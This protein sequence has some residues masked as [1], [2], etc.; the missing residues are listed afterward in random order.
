MHIYYA[1]LASEPPLLALAMSHW[2]EG[3]VCTLHQKL[4]LF[5]HWAQALEHHAQGCISPT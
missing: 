4:Q 5:G 2:E 3:I 1:V